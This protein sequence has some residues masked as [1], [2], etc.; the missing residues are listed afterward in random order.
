MKSSEERRHLQDPQ[1]LQ[2]SAPWQLMPRESPKTHPLHV[3]HTL[4]LSMR[5]PSAHWLGA[6]SVGRAMHRP[7]PGVHCQL[8]TSSCSLTPHGG[9][10]AVHHTTAALPAHLLVPPSGLVIFHHIP[11][12]RSSCFVLTNLS[13]PESRAPL[14]FPL[15]SIQCTQEKYVLYRHSAAK[16][17]DKEMDLDSVSTSRLQVHSPPP[18]HCPSIATGELNYKATLLAVQA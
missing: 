9:H 2:L 8:P 1:T 5:P 13:P 10:H 3:Q 14:S 16:N 6:S 15:G 4:G 12:I 7:S 17:T 18:K 11:Y